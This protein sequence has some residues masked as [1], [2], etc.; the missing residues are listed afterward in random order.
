VTSAPIVVFRTR[1]HEFQYSSARFLQAIDGPY[2]WHANGNQPGLIPIRICVQE[3]NPNAALTW[4]NTAE[5]PA[6]S[7]TTGA[8]SPRYV[9]PPITRPRAST[10]CVW[11]R[12]L[13]ERPR[14]RAPQEDRHLSV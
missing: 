10:Q 4:D 3:D 6:R 9:L 14:Q 8:E 13:D 7:T 1:L 11:R 5:L 2:P 12:V